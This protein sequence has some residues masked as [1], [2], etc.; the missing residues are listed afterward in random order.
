MMAT[1]A[2]ITGRSTFIRAEGRS[3]DRLSAYDRVKEHLHDAIGLVGLIELLS[4]RKHDL[5]RPPN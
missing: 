3:P 2:V 1:G 4:Q 5:A